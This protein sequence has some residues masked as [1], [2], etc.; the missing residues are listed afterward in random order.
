MPASVNG[1]SRDCWAIPARF[2]SNADENER[3]PKTGSLSGAITIPSITMVMRVAFVGGEQLRER[4][5]AWRAFKRKLL[6]TAEG[7]TARTAQYRLP[8]RSGPLCRIG[9][10]RSTGRQ[11]TEIDRRV[12]FIRI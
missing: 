5:P 3:P 2:P 11:L 12:R 8:L 10:S 4:A 9:V 6:D 1:G 7:L